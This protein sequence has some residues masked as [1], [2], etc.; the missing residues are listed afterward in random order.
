VSDPDG[1]TVALTAWL[2]TAVNNGDGGWS[3]SYQTTDGPAESQAVTISAGDG[4]GGSAQVSFA[5]TVENAAPTI[6]WLSISGQ[7]LAGQPLTATGTATDSSSDDTAAG[8]TW[9]WAIDGEAYTPGANSASVGFANCGSHTVSA[10]A[11]D[12]DG[13]VSQPVSVT[14][15]VYEG[16]FLA[17]LEEGRYNTVQAGR[18]V[19]VKVAVGCGGTAQTDLAPAIQLLKSDASAGE[20]SGTTP[21]ETTSSSAADATGLMRQVEGGHLYKLEVPGDAKPGDLY[22]I[23]VRPFGDAQSGA[24]LTVVLAIK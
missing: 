9:L 5:L 19:P 8:F 6:T 17:P 18:V 20:G 2:G 4:K 22:T 24:G 21:V 7:G 16:R 15:A 1:E 13:G 14:V 11:E 3:W 23:R 10:R 12:R